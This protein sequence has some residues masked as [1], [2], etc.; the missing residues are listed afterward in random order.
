MATED[1]SD[2][3][4]HQDTGLRLERLKGGLFELA[5]VGATLVGIVALLVLFGYI[6]FDAFRPLT[7]SA[8]WYLLYFGTLVTPTAAFTLYARSHPAVRSVNAKAFA[9]VFGTL[10][11]SLLTYVVADAVSPYDVLLYLFFG[12]VPPILVYTVARVTDERTYSGPAIPVS[13]LV[14]IAVAGGLYG[15]L[16]PLV[17][18][19]PPNG[20]RTSVLSPPL[21]QAYWGFSSPGDGPLGVDCTPQ[22]PFL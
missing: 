7:A 10:A 9:V 21:L 5:L 8:Q 12:T 19:V 4:L 6:A 3:K 20:S 15:L 18:V 13:I 11:V 14:G 2:D 16:R 17:G 1:E 22:L